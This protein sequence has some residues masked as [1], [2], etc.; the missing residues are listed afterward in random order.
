MVHGQ[1]V[2]ASIQAMTTAA[3]DEFGNPAGSP[4]RIGRQVSAKKRS[5]IEN[6]EDGTWSIAS[7]TPMVVTQ[8][9]D[10]G[11]LAGG[12][13]NVRHASR[14][15]LVGWPQH[16]TWQFVG[17]LVPAGRRNLTGFSRVALRLGQLAAVGDPALANPPNASQSVL[18]GLHDGSSTSW[19]SSAGYGNVLP[20]DQRP[21]GQHQ[22]VMSTLNIPLTAFSGINKNA[23]EAVYLAFPAGSQG[24]L[25]I[26]SVE[27]FKP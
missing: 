26:D 21:N 20:A 7:Q 27:W 22:S 2:P 6:F 8:V 4:A 18:V 14:V 17:L 23:V 9:V 11:D 1:H 10:E 5:V 16:N 12:T 19:V 3:P 25:L 13:M 15:G 24:T